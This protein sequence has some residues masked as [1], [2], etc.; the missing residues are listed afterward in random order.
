MSSQL[1][2]SEAD[3]LQVLNLP[4]SST[5]CAAILPYW[6]VWAA[7]QF[8]SVDEAKEL[9]QF[10]H[11]WQ[12]GEAIQV[13]STDGHRA[14]RYRIPT[15]AN[16]ADGI[17][18]LWRL[19]QQGLLLR[20]KPLQKAV[21]Y[22]KLLIITQDMRAVF[23]G[24]K[25]HALDELS[26]INLSGHYNIHSASDCGEVG[27]YP[28]INA[29]WPSS[30]TNQPN[31]RWAFNARFLREWGLVVEK[32]SPNAVTSMEGN[33]ARNPFVLRCDYEPRIGAH[34][35]DSQLELLLMPAQIRGK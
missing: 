35:E 2:R 29:I 33:G 27:R 3:Q 15:Q 22:A 17:P 16:T 12:D 24:G 28:S 20:A 7:A 10:V 4:Q 19:P 6:P 8:A 32:L 30:F 11:I 26:S 5:D 1:T 18:P 23:H 25:Q 31:Q 13:E 21:T 14:F 9:I 34:D